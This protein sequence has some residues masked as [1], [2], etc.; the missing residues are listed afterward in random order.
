METSQAKA[1]RRAL[2]TGELLPGAEPAS[3]GGGGEERV[4]RNA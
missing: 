4:G 1:E 2:A 3:G